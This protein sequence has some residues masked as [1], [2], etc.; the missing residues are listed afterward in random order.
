MFTYNLDNQ[1]ILITRPDAKTV[2]LNYDTGGRLEN[3]VIPRGSYINGYS[4]TTGNLDSIIAPDLGTLSFTYD[5]SLLNGSTWAGTVTGS[6]TRTYDNDFR[7][8]SRSIN[9]GNTINFGYDNDSLLTT[10]GAETLAYDP[11]NGLLTSTTLGVV[12]DSL[13]YNSFAEMDSYTANVS[14]SPVFSTS[15]VRDKLGRITQKTETVQGV[16]HVFDYTYDTGGRLMEVK[17]D[18]IITNTYTFDANGNRLNNGAVYDDQDRLLSQGSTTYTYTANGELVTKTDGGQ[19]TYNYDVLGNLIS[20]TLPDAT[21]IEYIVDGRN[22]RIGKK[23]N[24]ILERGWLYKDY[25]N[26][27]AELDGNGNLIS[28][29]V[30][31]SRTNVPDFIIKGSVTY[32]IISDHLG[33]PRLVVNTTNGTVIQAVDYDEWGNVVSDTNPGFHPFGFAGGFY[34]QDTKLTR[35]GAR[36]YDSEIGRWT[37]KDPAWFEGGEQNLYGYVFGD[38]INGIDPLGLTSLEFDVKNGKLTVDPEIK[39]VPPYVIDVTSGKDECINVIKCESI[40]DK[41]PIPRGKYSLNIKDLDDPNFV[42]DIGRQLTGD[43]GDWR[44]PLNPVEGTKTFG[45]DGFLLHGGR[46]PWFTRLYRYWRRYIWK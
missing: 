20:V 40:R 36:D 41:G 29:F 11:D 3:F 45:R 9:A 4:L 46:K 8:T 35:F 21:L 38:P 30:Y 42:W 15:F 17:K 37:I 12:N 33:S 34:D 16:T 10:A 43:W 7:I 27:I 2:A 6:V 26:P 32:R 1:L 13:T 25:L 19:T 22:R 5:G 18:S 39:G 44:I 24:G 23:V 31:S 14:G 28:R